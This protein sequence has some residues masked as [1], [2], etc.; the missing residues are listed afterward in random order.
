MV[1]L[2]DNIRMVMDDADVQYGEVTMW[3]ARAAM[4]EDAARA[5]S[6]A[7]AEA[8][9]KHNALQRKLDEYRTVVDQARRMSGCK[10][11]KF[12]SVVHLETLWIGVALKVSDFD[13]GK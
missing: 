3:K 10:Y 4:A 11:V 5:A 9:A 1:K 13:F 2:S 7:L 6:A 12:T 8:T